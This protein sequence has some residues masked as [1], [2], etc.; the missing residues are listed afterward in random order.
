[1]GKIGLAWTLAAMTSL[2]PGCY[3]ESPPPCP[4]IAMA[5]VVALTIQ[6]SYVD[7]VKSIRMKACQ[8]GACTEAELELFPGSV[9]VDQGCAP[10]GVCSATSS[11]DG[12]LH[13]NLFLPNLTE[14]PIDATVSGTSPSGTALPVRTL[15]FTPKG[16]YPFGEQCGRFITANLVLDADGLRQG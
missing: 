2:I 10:E 3:P 1:M 14:S 6:A 7:G 11:P 15:T 8:D 9:S 16:D 13:G 12:T 5:P 4:A